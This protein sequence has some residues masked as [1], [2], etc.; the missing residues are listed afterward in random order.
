MIKLPYGGVNFFRGILFEQLH[1]SA[2][3]SFTEEVGFLLKPDI[4]CLY[5]HLIN[6]AVDYTQSKQR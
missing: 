3:S 6:E 5:V 4:N 1:N 2:G